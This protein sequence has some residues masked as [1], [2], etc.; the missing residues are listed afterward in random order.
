M[1]AL[2]GSNIKPNFAINGL[3]GGKKLRESRGCGRN[4]ISSQCLTTSF[5]FFSSQ[6]YGTKVILRFHPHILEGFPSP[7][8]HLLRMNHTCPKGLQSVGC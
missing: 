1:L 3:N 6:K 2:D 4:I 5:M 8:L 7:M